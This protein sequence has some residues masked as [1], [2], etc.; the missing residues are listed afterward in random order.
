MDTAEVAAAVGTTPRLLR[1]FLRSDYS[2][3][4]SVGSGARY[5]FTERDLPTIEK[6]FAEWKGD[7]KPRPDNDRKPK[8]TSAKPK[9][10]AQVKRDADVWAEEGP[11]VFEDI[12]NPRVRARVRRD[13]QAAEDR[14]MQ[15]LLAA[16][17]HI[18]QL[19][20]RKPA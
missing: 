2:T 19:G 3:F 17:R 20:D 10:E 18:T 7:G 5:D 16:G 1:Q 4:Q 9:T 14:L 13:A 11:I 8:V 6:R 15:R 12:R